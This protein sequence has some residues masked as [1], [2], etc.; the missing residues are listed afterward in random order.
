MLGRW[1]KQ[2]LLENRIDTS[3]FKDYSTRAACVRKVHRRRMLYFV[4]CAG[5]RIVCFDGC[6][7]IL[8]SLIIYFKRLCYNKDFSILFIFVL[9]TIALKSHVNRKYVTAKTA[10]V[11]SL[12]AKILSTTG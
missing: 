8:L 11:I 5:K 12:V 6:I 4:S 10:S 2:I 7:V 1:I 9:A 3:V